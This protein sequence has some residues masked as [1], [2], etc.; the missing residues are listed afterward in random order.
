MKKIFLPTVAI[1]SLLIGAY[2]HFGS[3][4][5][6]SFFAVEYAQRDVY[7]AIDLLNYSNIPLAGPEG[8]NGGRLPGILLYLIYSL[9]LLVTKNVTSINQLVILINIACMIILFFKASVYN[10]NSLLSIEQNRIIFFTTSA[11]MS[12]H[13]L[14]ILTSEKILNPSFILLPSMFAQIFLIR[15]FIRNDHYFFLSI[16]IILLCLQIH[17][18]TI[19]LLASSLILLCYKYLENKTDVHQICLSSLRGRGLIY[20]IPLLCLVLISVIPYLI[21]ENS[22]FEPLFIYQNSSVLN[23]PINLIEFFKRLITG[24][25]GWDLMT[26]IW[27]LS[28]YSGDTMF[29]SNR[30]LSLEPFSIQKIIFCVGMIAYLN[31]LRVIYKVL[32]SKNNSSTEIEK[33]SFVI[34]T[35]LI[36]SS[37]YFSVFDPQQVSRYT[38]FLIFPSALSIGI[39]FSFIFENM[40]RKKLAMFSLCALLLTNSYE[41]FSV[42]KNYRMG[43]EKHV[44]GSLTNTQNFHQAMMQK[45]NLNYKEYLS[46]V[47]FCNHLPHLVFYRNRPFIPY[48]IYEILDD[49]KMQPFENTFDS[50]TFGESGIGYI[51]QIDNPMS[52]KNF[53]SCKNLIENIKNVEGVNLK[54]SFTTEFFQ[55]NPDPITKNPLNFTI[56]KYFFDDGHTP[57]SNSGDPF[58]QTKIVQDLLKSS[59]AMKDQGKNFFIKNENIKEFK[60]SDF[61]S[62]RLDL[63]FLIEKAIPLNVKLNIINDKITSEVHRYY[64]YTTKNQIKEIKVKLVYGN[65]NS[66]E[67]KIID[68]CGLESGDANIRVHRRSW[69]TDTT[70]NTLKQINIS[71]EPHHNNSFPLSKKSYLFSIPIDEIEQKIDIGDFSKSTC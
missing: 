47:Y 12:V 59:K 17:F 11:L 35:I 20:I 52:K 63:V 6:F 48:S 71:I 53:D 54:E 7:R 39:F 10:K 49:S 32:R 51:V 19:L 18:S 24:I 40:K 45:L 66:K 16:L 25:M 23:I 2:L 37:V 28:I 68:S 61:N 8:T 69:D 41:S 36:V 42:I 27:D 57:Y 60:K 38:L 44:G 46:K 67:H 56:Q 4:V 55:F 13:V 34:G 22:F 65:G 1:L 5:F 26:R 43:L 70:L 29:H 14:I 50:H 21:Y 62:L 31:V 30:Q 3:S 9:P 58:Y 15:G 64:F 33:I